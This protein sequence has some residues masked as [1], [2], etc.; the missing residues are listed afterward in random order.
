M[1]DL[2]KIC[3]GYTLHGNGNRFLKEVSVY[4]MKQGSPIYNIWIEAEL[5][6]HRIVR[7]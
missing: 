7:V 5:H 1:N 3:S 2:Q 4:Q 6:S